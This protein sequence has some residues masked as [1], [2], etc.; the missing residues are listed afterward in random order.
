MDTNNTT[1]LN[2][3]PTGP[4][5]PI[6]SPGFSDHKKEYFIVAIALIVITAGIIW[7]Q[8]GSQMNDVQIT[9]PI[10]LGD[11]AARDVNKI[12]ADILKTDNGNL[13]SDFQ[14]I[15]KDLNSL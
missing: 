8:L 9:A 10:N 14:Q 2:P 12:N 4:T 15:D 3:N 11:T 6:N 7:W 5:T 1:Q 13:D